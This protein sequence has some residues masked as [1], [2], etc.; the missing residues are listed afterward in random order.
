MAM[1]PHLRAAMLIVTKL[2]RVK[3][4]LWLLKTAE[5]RRTDWKLRNQRTNPKVML[6]KLKLTTAKPSSHDHEDVKL[7]M[8][9]VVVLEKL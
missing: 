6:K 1:I 4:E 8:K 7:K 3:F 2:E 5:I 9:P